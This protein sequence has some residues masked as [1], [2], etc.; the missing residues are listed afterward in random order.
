MNITDPMHIAHWLFLNIVCC[1]STLEYYSTTNTGLLE[2]SL[3][4]IVEWI[5]KELEF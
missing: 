3:W 5:T 1:I 4:D 2:P